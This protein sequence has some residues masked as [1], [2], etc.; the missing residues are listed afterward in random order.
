M[1]NPLRR[2]LRHLFWKPPTYTYDERVGFL[3]QQGFSP[4]EARVVALFPNIPAYALSLNHSQSTTCAACPIDTGTCPICGTFWTRDG[5]QRT[6]YK[7]SQET[8]DAACGVSVSAEG[9]SAAAAQETS[10]V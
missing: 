10:A 3:V 7:P 4:D 6:G 2:L 9:K 1:R 8:T 5:Y